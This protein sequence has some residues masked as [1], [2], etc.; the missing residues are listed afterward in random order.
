MC[1]SCYLIGATDIDV[2]CYKEYT[3]CWQARWS[4]NRCFMLYVT[5]TEFYIFLDYN[6]IE[7]KIMRVK[8]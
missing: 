1:C 5:E 4:G 6:V 2:I 7:E 8:I 3:R